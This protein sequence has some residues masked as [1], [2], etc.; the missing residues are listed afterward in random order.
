VSRKIIDRK[1]IES[2]SFAMPA[3]QRRGRAVMTRPLSIEN[4]E[5]LATELL[6]LRHSFPLSMLLCPFFRHRYRVVALCAYQIKWHL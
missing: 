4:G 6:S 5:A 2:F 1:I 3:S